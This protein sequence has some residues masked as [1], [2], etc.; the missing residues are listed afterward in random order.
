MMIGKYRVDTRVYRH[1]G[2]H[3][4]TKVEYVGA[5][6]GAGR[7]RSARQAH[8]KARE[9]APRE[10]RAASARTR[11]EG[12]GKRASARKKRGGFFRR[13]FSLSLSLL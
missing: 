1:T 11:R 3:S 12:R 10:G 13:L 2:V 5:F 9:R 4:W 8:T 6:A 7:I